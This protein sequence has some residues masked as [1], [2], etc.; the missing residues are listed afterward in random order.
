MNDNRKKT[1]LRKALFFFT[2]KAF[3]SWDGTMKSVLST[4]SCS[5]SHKGKFYPS[6]LQ[7]LRVVSRFLSSRFHPKSW[8]QFSFYFSNITLRTDLLMFEVA[9]TVCRIAGGMCWLPAYFDSPDNWFNYWSQPSNKNSI[10][11]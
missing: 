3:Y 10:T 8:Q 1:F 11:C 2:K 5:D 9:V 4:T 6:P 7:Q